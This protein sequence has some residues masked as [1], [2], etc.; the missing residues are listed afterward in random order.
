MTDV[1]TAS[2]MAERIAALDTST[3]FTAYQHGDGTEVRV[4]PHKSATTSRIWYSVIASRGGR[5]LWK[6]QV[7]YQPGAA[8][9]KARAL[10]TRVQR[11]G[12]QP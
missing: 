4:I 12:G 7:A 8:A 1:L 9:K 10:V 3:M 2:Q 11:N 5:A 6:K